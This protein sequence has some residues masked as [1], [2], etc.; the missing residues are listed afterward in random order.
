MLVLAWQIEEVLL[1]YLS[2]CRE[3]GESSSDI[4]VYLTYV[5][6]HHVQGQHT[7]YCQLLGQD[8]VGKGRCLTSSSLR[9]LVTVRNTRLL[10]RLLSSQEGALIPLTTIWVWFD[11][12]LQSFLP[13]PPTTTQVFTHRLVTHRTEAIKE[14]L[15]L[16]S[17]TKG[18]LERKK[19]STIS[20]LVKL[21]SLPSLFCQEDGCYLKMLKANRA[22]WHCC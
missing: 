12:S 7:S 8:T 18:L 15:G 16:R 5:Y 9:Q 11:L 22:C 2:W 14:A 21:A 20:I 4:Y 10:Y 1:F 13:S 3:V 17:I 19:R 6:M